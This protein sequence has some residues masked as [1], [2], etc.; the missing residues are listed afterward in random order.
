MIRLSWD[1]YFLKIAEA[2]A[3][4]SACLSNQKGCIIVR[5]NQI[6]SSGYSGPPS[7]IP[8]C[9]WRDEHG[10]YMVN[11]DQDSLNVLGD[12]QPIYKCPRHRAGFHSGEGLEICPSVHAEANAI[13]QASKNGISTVGSTLYTSFR[14]IP[15][16]E[17][18]KLIINAGIL[19]VVSNGQPMVYAQPGMTGEHLL[20]MAKI[21]VIDGTR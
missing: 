7:R 2:T 19:E 12:F 14:E 18:A 20:K 10:R 8:H 4:R 11:P 16:R 21:E 15:C 1:K 9:E 3:L 5:N 13:I 6:I 17:C